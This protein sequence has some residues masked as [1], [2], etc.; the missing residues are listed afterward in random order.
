M[1]NE[2]IM[3]ATIAMIIEMT[4]LVIMDDSTGALSMVAE[5]MGAFQLIS[6]PFLP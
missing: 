4:M 2:G 3:I 1:I 6:F 5:L